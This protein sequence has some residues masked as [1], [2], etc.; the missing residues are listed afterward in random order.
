MKKNNITIMLNCLLPL[1]AGAVI[2]YLFSPDVIF[3]KLIDEI[4]GCGVHFDIVSQGNWALNILRYYV[5]DILWAYALVFALYFISG[6]ETANLKKIFFITFVFS[7]A[8]EFLQLTPLAEGTFDISDIICEF[9]A[10]GIAVFVI[11]KIYGRH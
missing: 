5:L 2:Y 1:F 3:V 6:N 9:F 11:K 8:M 10:E 7:M 4:I